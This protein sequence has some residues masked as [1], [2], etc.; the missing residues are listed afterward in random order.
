MKR[1]TASIC[2]TIAVLLGS[3]GEGFALP[4]CPSDQ[5]K[6]YDN[7]F[8]TYT[9]ANGDKYVGEWNDGKQNGQGTY[10]FIGDNQFKGD[11]Y[12]GEFKDGKY[13]GQGTFAY[14]KS[15]NK[16]VVNTR[17]ANGTDRAPIPL[18]MAR[19]RKAFGRTVNLKMPRNVHPQLLLLRRINNPLSQSGPFPKRTWQN[20]KS[21]MH[22]RS[23]I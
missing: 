19:Q 3:A 10:Y 11:K 9:Y 17:M 22:V 16:H 13:D 6:Y 14:A 21:S 5:S 23:V 8:G 15:G 7:C 20:S 18:P 12:V 1:V 2:L 4:P